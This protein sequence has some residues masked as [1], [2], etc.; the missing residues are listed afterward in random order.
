MV[1]DLQLDSDMDSIHY[2]CDVLT[3]GAMSESYV[4][5]W[6][7]TINCASLLA[8]LGGSGKFE[9]KI[10]EIGGILKIF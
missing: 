8:G 1:S 6:Q 9:R 5:F 10:V 3:Q 7:G 4:P 2:S